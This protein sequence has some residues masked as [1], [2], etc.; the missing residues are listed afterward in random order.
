MGENGKYP[1]LTPASLHNGREQ[2]KPVS[3]LPEQSAPEPAPR[4]KGQHIP[5]GRD[6]QQVL[7]AEAATPDATD[8][9]APADA[10]PVGGP[11]GVGQ[12]AAAG[13]AEALL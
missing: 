11:M 10:S 12:P 9:D 4:K 13:P 6:S 1:L 2:T 8:R 7:K 3:G 5:E